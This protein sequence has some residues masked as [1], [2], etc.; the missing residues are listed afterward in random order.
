MNKHIFS[1]PVFA[2]LLVLVLGLG[3]FS[4]AL[5]AQPPN[6]DFDAATV[7]TGLPFTDQIDTS[8]ATTG[9]D[10]PE[11]AG[12]GHTVWYA[13][14]PGQDMRIAADT[15]GSYF[16][17]DTTLSVYTGTRGDLTQI[18]C[19]DD[20]NGLQ[21]RVVFDATAGETYYFMVGAYYDQ[22][23]GDL[24]FNVDLG[25]PPLEFDLF[26][27][28]LGQVKA[29]SGSVILSGVVNCSRPAFV[30]VYG[31]AQQRAGR[32]IIQGY[33]Y[34]FVE[35]NGETPWSTIFSGENG[36]FKAGQLNVE[37]SSFAYT[38]DGE[39][40]EDYEGLNVRLRGPGK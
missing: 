22:P 2:M 3:Y 6:D 23:G 7:I 27:N 11:C 30:D 17:F 35:C 40:A 16:D 1:R 5:A 4:I 37:A 31:G 20:T 24:V 28:P 14:T 38:D 39:F 26:V 15:F 21:S 10:D 36:I 12:N 8:E 32:V 19:N 18:A 29:S 13:F 33:F 25:P 34:T 9:F